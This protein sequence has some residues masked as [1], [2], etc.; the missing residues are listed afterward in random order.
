MTG[1]M[2]CNYCNNRFHEWKKYEHMCKEHAADAYK[3]IS[4]ELLTILKGSVQRISS[5]LENTVKFSYSFERK[6][7][8]IKLTIQSIPQVTMLPYNSHAFSD[9]ISGLTNPTNPYAPYDLILYELMNSNKEFYASKRLQNIP[10]RFLRK[11]FVSFADDPEIAQYAELLPG[12]KFFVATF[13]AFY[14]HC[15]YQIFK[16]LRFSF[17]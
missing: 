13:H 1:V 11:L 15:G 6:L 17:Q 5:Y 2:Q 3:E 9:I 7:L 16:K 10:K 12:K 14:S 8:I 4:E